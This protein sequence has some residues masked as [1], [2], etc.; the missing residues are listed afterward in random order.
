[1]RKVVF[2]LVAWLLTPAVSLAA[3]AEPSCDPA[4]DPTAC[5]ISAPINVSDSGQTKTGSLTIG[6]GGTFTTLGVLTATG[7]ASFSG[8]FNVSGAA[9]FSNTASFS[10][11]ITATSGFTYSGVAGNFIITA[12]SINDS[13]VSNTLTASN[14]VAAAG[15]NAVDL[16]TSEV[17]G[18]LPSTSITD[19]WVNTSGD[20]MTGGLIV[21]PATAARAISITPYSTQEAIYI[22]GATGQPLV[23]LNPTGGSS[24]QGLSISMTSGSG[25]GENIVLSGT[26]TG[27][28]L[29]IESSSSSNVVAINATGSGYPVDIASTGTATRSIN[30]TNGANTGY[31]VYASATVAGGIGVAGTGAAYGVSGTSPTGAGVYGLSVSGYGGYFTSN[32]N[33]GTALYTTLA[34]SSTTS[35]SKALRVVGRNGYGAYITADGDSSIGLYVENTNTTAGISKYAIQAVAVTPAGEGIYAVSDYGRA[36]HFESNFG[37]T[38][39]YIDADG[40]TYGIDI[41]ASGTTAGIDIDAAGGDTGLNITVDDYD[42]AVEANGGDIKTTGGFRGGQFYANEPAGNGIYKNID[43]RYVFAEALS[44]GDPVGDL[45]FDGNSIWLGITAGSSAYSSLENRSAVDGHEMAS[46]TMTWADEG[47]LALVD[48]EIYYFSDGGTYDIVNRLDGTTSSGS[49]S[50]AIIMYSLTFDGSSIWF[51]TGNRVYEW[52]NL[53]TLSAR[54]TGIGAIYDLLYADGYIWAVDN[55]NDV[56]R[57]IQTSS[58][59]TSTSITVGSDPISAVYDGQYIWVANYTGNSLTRINT[60]DSSTVTYDISSFGTGPQDLAFDGSNIWIAYATSGVGAFNVATES[61]TKENDMAGADVTDLVFD[62]T[63]LWAVSA[64]YYLF[65]IAIGSGFGE[66]SG[67]LTDGILMYNTAGAV[68]CLYVSGSTVTASSTLTNCQ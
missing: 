9:V 49:L 18:I 24:G 46:A 28:A 33:A 42:S 50:L 15:T 8:N 34:S 17:A 56:V 39:V 45:L 66:T 48:D 14:F 29:N 36:G 41:E 52:S 16:G 54:V 23:S 58:P 10:N 31:G 67:G 40:A 3:W 38:G 37:G 2:V 51:G 30:V 68:R 61:L 44:A 32:T 13:E 5:E 22:S 65:K 21:N 12:N 53:S 25:N 57:K 26:A 59:Y 19:V 63:Y 6:A 35:N 1:M 27:K 60:D 4:A 7:S 20:T 62:G 55:T 64:D 43:P 11:T 47:S